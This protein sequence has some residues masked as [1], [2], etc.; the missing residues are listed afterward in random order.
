MHKALGLTPNYTHPP[1]PLQIRKVGSNTYG[2]TFIKR[3]ERWLHGEEHLLLFGV[4][5]LAST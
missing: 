2:L 4:Q 1:H 3:L 5:F